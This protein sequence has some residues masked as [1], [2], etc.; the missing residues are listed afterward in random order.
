MRQ[1][2]TLRSLA[3]P[4]TS[5]R[6]GQG[7]RASWFDGSPGHGGREQGGYARQLAGKYHKRRYSSAR[8]QRRCQLAIGVGSVQS[9]DGPDAA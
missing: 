6:I 3:W 8:T 4:M 5:P 7:T 9:D 2:L 1:G